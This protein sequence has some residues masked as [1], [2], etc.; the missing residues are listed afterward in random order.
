MLLCIRNVQK[1]Q[2]HRDKEDECGLGAGGL[3]IGVTANGCEASFWGDEDGLEV[4]AESAHCKG[5]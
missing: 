2:T 5:T 3:G 4:V 1:Q